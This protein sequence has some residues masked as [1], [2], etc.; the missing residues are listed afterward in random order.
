MSYAI[1]LELTHFLPDSPLFSPTLS[2]QSLIF[3][4]FS[5]FSFTIA[6]SMSIHHPPT[7]SGYSLTHSLIHSLTLSLS[8]LFLIPFSIIFYFLIL[9]FSSLLVHKHPAPSPL[10]SLC[11]GQTTL[12]LQSRFFNSATPLSDSDFNDSS[13]TI[14]PPLWCNSTVVAVTSHM[15]VTTMNQG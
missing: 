4:T 3:K 12:L 10:V 11:H 9:S 8:L 1:L 15:V 5:R 7:I 6:I 14:P 13:N 2:S